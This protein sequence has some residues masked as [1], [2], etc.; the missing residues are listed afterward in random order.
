MWF[1]WKINWHTETGFLFLSNITTHLF[2]LYIIFI[3]FYFLYSLSTR[4]L[5]LIT[6]VHRFIYHHSNRILISIYFFT[7]FIHIHF[8]NLSPIYVH[9]PRYINFFSSFFSH[10]SDLSFLIQEGDNID[11]WATSCFTPNDK[12]GRRVW[13]GDQLAVLNPDL[14]EHFASM[15]SHNTCV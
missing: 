8:Y 5:L 12:H 7:N 6:G 4:L 9:I 14:R 15:F 3:L 10:S 13:I 2:S 11:F 1:R